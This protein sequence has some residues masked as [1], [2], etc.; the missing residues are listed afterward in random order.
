MRVTM[1]T[2]F[3]LQAL[4]SPPTHSGCTQE[5]ANIRV[6]SSLLY[7][8][9]ILYRSPIFGLSLNNLLLVS[10][11]VTLLPRNWF[12]NLFRVNIKMLRDFRFS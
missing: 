4:P 6:R 3:W 1:G 8:R 11:S 2:A 12:Q 5:D 9:P 7:E 10:E